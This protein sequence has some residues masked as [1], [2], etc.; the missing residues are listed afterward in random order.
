MPI[1]APLRA[2]IAPP[3]ILPGSVRVRLAPSPT[4][5]LHIGTARTALFNLLF[6]RK[7]R[8]VFVLR[9]EDTDLERSDALFEKDIVENLK[10][11]GISWDEGIE[12]GGDFSPYR[13]SERVATYAKDLERLL[14]G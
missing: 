14:G 8:G 10:W 1:I 9:I 11:L 2:P 12:V 6:A 3:I 13:R 7:Y 5:A 4:G